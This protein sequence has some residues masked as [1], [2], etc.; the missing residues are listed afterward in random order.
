ME[1]DYRSHLSINTQKLIGIKFGIK[2]F[3]TFAS[4]QN[5]SI[6][7]QSLFLE[8]QICRINVAHECSRPTELQPEADM[9]A[10]FLFRALTLPAQGSAWVAGWCPFFFPRDSLLAAARAIYPLPMNTP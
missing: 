5:D 10:F 8:M 7:H 4:M 2:M 1:G 3:T 9:R 6:V